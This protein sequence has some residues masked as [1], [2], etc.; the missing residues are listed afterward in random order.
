MFLIQMV[1]LVT[2][3][4]ILC[5]IIFD[6][7]E[8]KRLSKNKAVLEDFWFGEEKRNA[9][10]FKVKLDIMYTIPENPGYRNTCPS[11]DIST[12]GIQL[13]L[14]EKLEKDTII[15]LELDLPHEDSK[16]KITAKGQVVWTKESPYP[17]EEGLRIFNAGIKF[18]Q[19]N[20]TD[21]KFLADYLQRNSF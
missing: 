1:M 17:N 13:T 19:I 4:V 12:S 3:V 11:N 14:R 20:E 9:P 15:A 5:V 6:E 8:N 21:E 18:I 16:K 10:R 7:Y 2:V